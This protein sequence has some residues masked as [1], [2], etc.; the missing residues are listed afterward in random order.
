M[1]TIMA[2]CCRDQLKGRSVMIDQGTEKIR[3]QSPAVHSCFT[4]STLP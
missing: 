2:F 3:L 1:M 4:E